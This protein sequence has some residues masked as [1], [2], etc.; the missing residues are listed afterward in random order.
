[1]NTRRSRSPLALPFVV[2]GLCAAGLVAGCSGQGDSNRQHVSAAKERMEALKGGVEYQMAMEQ[3]MAGELEKALRS[4]DKAIVLMEESS[5]AQV[6]RGRI[7]IERGDLE[8]AR[9]ALLRAEELDPESAEAQYYLGIVHERFSQPAEALARHEKALAIE[10]RNAQYVIATAEMLIAAQRLDEADALLNDQKDALAHNSAIRQCQGQLAM[11][12]SDYNRAVD[13][14]VQARLLAPDDAAVLEDLA[15][16]QFAA[17]RFSD[18]EF[19]LS[20][21]LR[22]KGFE[23]RQDVQQLRAQCF[24]NLERYVEARSILQ[25]ITESETGSNDL[26][27]WITLGKV[28]A[29]LN[30]WGH[31]RVASTR[32]IAIAPERSEGYML[33]A[34][35]Q[36]AAGDRNGA[37][38][39]LDKAAR[40]APTDAAPLVLKSLVQLDLNRRDDARKSAAAAVERS[41]ADR[42]AQALL[43]AIDS[44]VDLGVQP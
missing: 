3:F 19:T 41:P 44:G 23:K 10:P 13:C 26:S 39:T 35:Q 12:R 34:M 36:R 27:A 28:C 2:L 16:A 40:Y 9:V 15:R 21:L 14:F 24:A 11:L 25:K 42:D 17:R 32:V 22:Q 30:D 43:T 20:T 6:L 37:L 1:M 31:V 8:P 4:V 5:K 18:A 29:A 38:A 33:K 7:L